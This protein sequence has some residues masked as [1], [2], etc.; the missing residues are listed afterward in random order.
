MYLAKCKIYIGRAS[1]GLPFFLPYMNY[2][3]LSAS[4]TFEGVN[5]NPGTQ[6]KH[7]HDERVDKIFMIGRNRMSD[8][9]NPDEQRQNNRI[10]ESEGYIQDNNPE[11]FPVNFTQ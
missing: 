3:P 10:C 8:N 6:E 4:P 1:K 11:F 2:L 7:K 5:G 9:D